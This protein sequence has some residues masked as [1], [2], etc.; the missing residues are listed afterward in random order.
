M[1]QELPRRRTVQ[2]TAAA[3][4]GSVVLVAAGA[5]AVVALTGSDL[6][7]GP[8]ASALPGVGAT[9]PVQAPAGYDRTAIWSVPVGSEPQVLLTP[10]GGVLAAPV[11]DDRFAILDR[12]TGAETWAGRDPVEGP[13]H[14]SQVG[15]EAVLAADSPGTLHTWPLDTTDPTDVTPTAI[16]LG[17]DQAEVTYDGTAPLVV[18]P[19]QRVALLDRTSAELISRDVPDGTTPV[20]AT[21]QHVV[22]V[23]AYSWW[24]ITADEDPVPHRLHKPAE[25]VGSP[26]AAI[27]VSGNQ[28]AVVWRTADPAKDVL[29]LVG[30][31][32]NSIRATGLIRSSAVPPDAEPLRD[33]AGSTRTIGPVLLD[34]GP[35]PLVTDLGDITPEAVLGRSVHGTSKGKPAVATWSPDGVELE[36]DESPGEHAPV[37]A[38]TRDAAFVVV[39]EGD[40]TILYA[41][42][43][44]TS[45]PR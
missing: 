20:S 13:L 44:L 29:A 9:L 2:L 28:L 3:A 35:E 8:T 27:A 6:L 17:S 1:S 4:A 10:Y 18:L 5:I 43:R 21:P 31:N 32:R 25:A 45:S 16:D 11:G 26:T 38:L 23:G 37:A 36:V 7:P 33:R 24:T 42:P 41:L 19:D 22:A 30:L 12:A 40:E 34:V 14:L 39:P 15:E